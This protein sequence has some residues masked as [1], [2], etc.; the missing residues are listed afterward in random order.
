LRKPSPDFD[1]LRC[2]EIINF[3]QANSSAVVQPSE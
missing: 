3:H 2:S 1:P